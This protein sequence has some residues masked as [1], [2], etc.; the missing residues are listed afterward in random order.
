MSRKAFTR[1]GSPNAYHRHDP[2]LATAGLTLQAAALD[3]HVHVMAGILPNKAREIFSIPDDYDIVT[4]F[5]IGYRGAPDDLPEAL[6]QA[7]RVFSD[8]WGSA[9][10]FTSLS[11]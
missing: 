9:A 1:N 6:R 7:E 2:G 3:L 10:N 5:A 11:T 8:T 4:A